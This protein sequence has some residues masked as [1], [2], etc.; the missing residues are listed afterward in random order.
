M[1]TIHD[2]AICIKR[3]DWS[4][5]SQ[6]VTLLTREHGLLRGIAKGAKRETGRFSGGIELL[7]R[8][9]VGAADRRDRELL[10]LTEWDLQEIF[11]AL[12]T[13]LSA[14]RIGLYLADVA[15]HVLALRDPHPA[16]YDQLLAGL[17]V[18]GRPDASP[19]DRSLAL[20]RCQLS[21]LCET[22]Y[23]P[24]L[25]SEEDGPEPTDGADGGFLAFNP[26][27]G[28]VVTDTGEADRWR[29]RASTIRTLRQA[30]A[31]N[32]G[33]LPSLDRANRLLAAYLRS[34]LDRELPTMRL[35]FGPNRTTR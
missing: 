2:Q 23:E 5:T 8:G 10:T 31:D 21:A 35:L 22:G 19:W 6:T 1:P 9:E 29:V 15:Q 34:V 18:L 13:D 28:S 7:T 24:M 26:L 11:W 17:R 33:E 3:H 27:A 25:G 4:E 16:L 12:R 14:H 32:P 30:D 20:M